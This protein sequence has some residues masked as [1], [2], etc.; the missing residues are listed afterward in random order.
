[1]I[2]FFVIPSRHSDRGF[3]RTMVSIMLM[4]ALSVA[5][6]ALPALPKTFCTSGIVSINLSCTCIILLISEFETSGKVTGM[7]NSDPSS[8]GGI[9]SR[10]ILMT[11]G[12]LNMTKARDIAIVV[13]FQAKHQRIT[14]EYRKIKKRETGCFFS[15][16][17]FPLSNKTINTGTTKTATNAEPI[18]ANVFVHTN[19]EKS[20]C[21]WPVK[22]RIGL[23]DTSVTSIEL[24]TAFAIIFE[25]SSILLY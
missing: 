1:M 10:P 17:T 14:G 5:V 23:K 6:L 3:K 24:T 2:S 11:K 12:M 19:G 8:K 21:S 4:G 13:F 18:I 20:L 25:D 9:N 22:N 7:N 16:L 15:G